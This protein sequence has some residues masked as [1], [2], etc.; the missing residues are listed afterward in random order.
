MWKNENPGLRLEL[1]KMDGAGE[2][3]KYSYQKAKHKNNII[4]VLDKKLQR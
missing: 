3:I 4:Q 1:L 2:S